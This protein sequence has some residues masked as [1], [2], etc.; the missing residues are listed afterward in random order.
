ML[1]W[2]RPRTPGDSPLGCMASGTDDTP[3]SGQKVMWGD[4]LGVA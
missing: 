2:V 3:L 4:P 1:S